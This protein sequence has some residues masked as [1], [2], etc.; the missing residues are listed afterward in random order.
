MRRTVSKC[1]SQLKFVRMFSRSPTLT[2]LIAA[3]GLALLLVNGAQQC[4]AI[5]LLVDC[6]STNVGGSEADVKQSCGGR[7]E[8]ATRIH[9]SA[10]RPA[11]D[12]STLSQ[13][14]NQCPSDE[15]C[16]CCDSPAPSKSS[17]LGDSQID[18]GPSPLDVNSVAATDELNFGWHGLSVHFNDR[19]SHT[20]P[21][22]IALCRLIV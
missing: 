3:L 9:V 16:V 13:G 2:K 19:T 7:C 15:P 14:A 10:E 5:C 21:V 18:L 12:A 22:C 6:H 8:Q 4:R 20:V 11:T 1:P 17:S